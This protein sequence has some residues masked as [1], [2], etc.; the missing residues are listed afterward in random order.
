MRIILKRNIKES[1]NF[2]LLK[3]FFLF[4]RKPGFHHKGNKYCPR[5]FYLVL[6]FHAKNRCNPDLRQ[7]PFYHFEK[8]Y[9]RKLEAFLLESRLG[10]R[11]RLLENLTYR[12]MEEL[13]ASADLFVLPS[14]REP[15]S[16]SQLEAM[17]FSVPAI[18]S[19]F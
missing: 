7:K 1:W 17:S 9:K 11:V 5:L 10:E 6:P 16:V 12:Q 15:A 18:C 3:P 2:T 4:R 8:E 13:Y 14:T 19:N